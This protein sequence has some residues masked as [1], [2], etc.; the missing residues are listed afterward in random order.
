MSKGYQ[1]TEYKNQIDELE[2]H[3]E[4]MEEN[5]PEHTQAIENMYKAA[6]TIK[7]LAERIQDG[8]LIKGRDKNH[9]KV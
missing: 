3:A 1:Y 6:Q 7:F 5:C 9:D 4:F 2:L 8:D